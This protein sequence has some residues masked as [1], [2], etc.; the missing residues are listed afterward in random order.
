MKQSDPSKTGPV[1]RLAD[2][3]NRRAHDC[4]VACR[5]H[6]GSERVSP[7]RSIRAVIEVL[8]GLVH[9]AQIRKTI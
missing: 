9:S 5:A 6:A 4:P 7:Y 2:L 3:H 8:L 1:D